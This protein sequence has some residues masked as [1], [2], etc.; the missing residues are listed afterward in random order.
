MCLCGVK[1]AST[2][3]ATVTDLA[4]K[5]ERERDKQES[6]IVVR[7]GRVSLGRGVETLVSE[8][9]FEHFEGRGS[10]NDSPIG[11]SFVTEYPGREGCS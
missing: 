7:C 5:E 2:K 6:G 8:S 4:E 1:V 9:A 3:K 11:C 10:H